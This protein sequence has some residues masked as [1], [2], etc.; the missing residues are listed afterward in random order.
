MQ[1][2]VVDV[3]HGIFVLLSLSKIHMC[4]QLLPKFVKKSEVASFFTQQ[5]LKFLFC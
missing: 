2:F 4:L 1:E 3:A 5:P